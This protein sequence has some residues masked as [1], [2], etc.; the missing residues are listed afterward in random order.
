[1]D[2][3]IGQGDSQDGVIRKSAKGMKQREPGRLDVATLIDRSDDVAGN[4]TQHEVAPF[5]MVRVDRR[6]LTNGRGL[7]SGSRLEEVSGEV[8]NLAKQEVHAV[9]E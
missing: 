6:G 7:L 2:E 8:G 9:V 5:E 1:M 3:T 4:G